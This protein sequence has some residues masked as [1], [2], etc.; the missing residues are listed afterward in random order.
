MQWSIAE[1]GS[2]ASYTC[3]FENGLKFS[4][5]LTAKDN[6]VAQKI[7]MHNG[8]DRPIARMR[9]TL[10]TLLGSWRELQNDDDKMAHLDRTFTLVDGKLI[11]I[12]EVWASYSDAKRE[13]AEGRVWVGCNVR[14]QK[15][16]NAQWYI[17]DKECDAGFIAVRSKERTRYV[18]LHWPK[19]RLVFTNTNVPCIHADPGLGGCPPGEQVSLTGRILFHD[20]SVGPL[21]AHLGLTQGND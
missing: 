15:S 1:D 11:T 14:G 10:C 6:E 3:E 5:R 18:A 2:A 7:R 8:S 12:A 13:P 16:K 9:P 19:C 21:M 17:S 4:V 20:G